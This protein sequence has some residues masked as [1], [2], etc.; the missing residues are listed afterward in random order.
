MVDPTTHLLIRA[1][2]EIL[3]EC[4]EIFFSF[5]LVCLPIFIEEFDDSSNVVWKTVVILPILSTIKWKVYMEVM[6]KNSLHFNTIESLEE[7]FWPL[8]L[9]YIYRYTVGEL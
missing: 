8:G 5:C 2:D 6:N 7:K 9:T 3:G 1:T 4:L